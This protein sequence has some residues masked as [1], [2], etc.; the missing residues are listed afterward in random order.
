ML[1]AA[2]LQSLMSDA[3]LDCSKGWLAEELGWT[4]ENAARRVTRY[5]EGIEEMPL[6]TAKHIIRIAAEH[7]FS[8]DSQGTWRPI[9]T[10]RGEEK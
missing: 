1:T 10:T 7:G 5:A 4:G 8:L 9:P 6:T 3:A 2:Q